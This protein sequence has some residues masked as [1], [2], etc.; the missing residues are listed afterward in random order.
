VKPINQ[1]QDSIAGPINWYVVGERSLDAT[2]QVDFNGVRVYT[3]NQKMHRYETAFRVRNIRGVYPLEIGQDK[4]NPTF[5][6]YELG[7]DGTTKTASE[8]VMYGVV[9]RS[10]NAPA[11]PLKARK[12]AKR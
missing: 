3:W 11:T 5:R 10:L 9:T 2:P 12:A 1:V 6:Y 7:E 4:G 8:Y